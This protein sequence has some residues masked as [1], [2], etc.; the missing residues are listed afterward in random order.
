MTHRIVFGPFETD[1]GAGELRREGVVVPIQDLPFRLL[2]ALLERPGELLTRVELTTRLWG[3]DTFVDS[4]AGLNTAVAK[5]REALGDDADK[6][7]YIETVPKR[8]YRFIGTIGQPAT[9]HPPQTTPVPSI[10]RRRWPII[11]AT[12][13]V[14]AVAGAAYQLRA[15]REPFRVAVVLFDNETGDAEFGRLSQG[16]TDA[17]VTD[18]TAESRLAVIGNAAVLRTTRPF[19]DIATVRDALGADYI[20]IG[21]VQTARSTNDCA[22]ASD[23]QPRPGACLGGRRAARRCQRGRVSIGRRRQSARGGCRPRAGALTGFLHTQHDVRIVN[24]QRDPA[25]GLGKSDAHVLS[26]HRIELVRPRCESPRREWPG[27]PTCSS[28]PTTVTSMRSAGDDPN[29]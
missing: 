7:L 6:P 5:L 14:I 22:G 20:V 3:T 24:G 11:A 25:R 29:A 8:G 9:P 28:S 13:G 4:T 2:A 10:S 16:L 17:V 1:M 18:L 15:T 23:S 26:A 21:Q 27:R 19:R 12:L